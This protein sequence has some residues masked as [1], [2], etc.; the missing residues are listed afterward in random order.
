MYAG[1]RFHRYTCRAFLLALGVGM[2]IVVA[3][4]VMAQQPATGA[5][6][7]T[8]VDNL[9]V[10][11][12]IPYRNLFDI[13]RDGGVLMVPILVCSIVLTV[14]TF[15]RV[16]SLRKGRVVPGPFVKRFLHQ[17]RNKQ[18]SRSEAL[19]LCQENRSPV[20][21]VFAAALRKWGRP[22]V[23]VEQAMLDAGERV[24]N[25]LRKYLRVLN[26]VAT[27]TPLMGLLG[28]VVGMIQAFNVVAQADALG[29]PELLAGGISQALLTTAGGLTVA[30]PALILYLFFVSRVDKHVMIIDALGQ[31]VVE[32]IAGD[33]VEVD[34]GKKKTRSPRKVA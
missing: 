19:Q 18:L 10:L 25:H 7:D 14:F 30:I 1:N 3:T 5:L 26:G 29:R 27:V 33:A 4:Y 8:K 24:A 11:P 12:A 17:L 6:S 23:E 16:I 21:D 20:S 31:E 32:L 9:E 34:Q 22:G 2:Q 13:V 15:E 28:T